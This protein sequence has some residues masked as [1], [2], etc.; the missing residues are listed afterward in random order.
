M[1]EE[2]VDALLRTALNFC[3]A[4]RGGCECATVAALV[5]LDAVDVDATTGQFAAEL[6]RIRGEC[7]FE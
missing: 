3:S 7:A 4:F 6:D 5:H 2:E 1:L